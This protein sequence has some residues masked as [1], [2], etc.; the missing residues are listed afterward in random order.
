[1]KIYMS[2]K[3]LVPDWNLIPLHQDPGEGD[4]EVDLMLCIC[5][6]VLKYIIENHV[7]SQRF[8]STCLIIEVSVGSP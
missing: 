2:D 1:M 3:Q 6:P 8:F 7:G 5:H 4:G